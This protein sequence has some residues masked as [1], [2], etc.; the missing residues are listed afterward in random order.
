[1]R[2][3]AHYCVNTSFV[4]RD[5][6][7][8]EIQIAELIPAVR[9]AAV[10]GAAVSTD[11]WVGYARLRWDGYRHATV[12]HAAGEW[13]RD[14]EGTASG[15]CTATPWRGCGRGCGTSCGRPAG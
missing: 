5:A 11:E 2:E 1:E 10:P 14:D 6:F 12:N 4:Q 7:A 3:R 15:R 9:A 8:G 13:A